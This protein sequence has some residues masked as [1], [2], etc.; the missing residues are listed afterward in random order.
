ML[1]LTEPY[2][3]LLP[4]CRVNLIDVLVIAVAHKEFKKMGV[5]KIK[6]FGKKEAILFDLKYMFKKN[7]SDLRI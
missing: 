1:L 3:Q 7:K 2:W 5:E 4:E 6:S